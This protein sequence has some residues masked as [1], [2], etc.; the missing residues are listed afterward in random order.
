M[1]ESCKE[2]GDAPAALSQDVT[3]EL[4]EFLITVSGFSQSAG[5]QTR[6]TLLLHQLMLALFGL[7]KL[8]CY[9]HQTQVY[10]EERTNL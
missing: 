1:T 3:D 7:R 9:D 10:H 8:C 2:R 4:K 6:G 5:G